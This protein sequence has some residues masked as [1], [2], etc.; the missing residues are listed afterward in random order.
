MA[1]P[2]AQRIS[3]QQSRRQTSPWRS[4]RRREPR[5]GAPSRGSPRDGRSR[6]GLRDAPHPLRERVS[7]R[8]GAA[9]YLARRVAGRWLSTAALAEPGPA[10]G[11]AVPLAPVAPAA[12]S[13][14]VAALT[15]GLE[16]A[17]ARMLDAR[18]RR[19]VALERG[20]L[21]RMGPLLLELA[22]R[23]AYRELGFRSLDAHARERLG[24]APRKARA[25]LRLERASCASPTLAA[26][27]RAGSLSGSHAQALVAL[28]LAEGSCRWVP[29]WI[30][31]AARV[32][33]R[34]LEDDVDHALATG[35]L[36]PAALPALPGPP[37]LEVPV[38]PAGVQTGARPRAGRER[39]RV[40]IHAPVEVVRL[41]HGARLLLLR[42]PAR[43]SR[44]VPLGRGRG[45]AREPDDA[46]RGPPPAQRARTPSGRAP[47]RLRF[48]TPLGSWASGDVLRT[49]RPRTSPAAGPR[50]RS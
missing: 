38:D 16:A 43:P 35:N 5:C 20:L 36:D 18:L 41:L 19:A 32:S 28:V 45:R 30:A 2:V 6:G 24:M 27:W 23:G 1:E 11:P 3:R 22:C 26:A 50:C 8:W 31:R 14:F 7:A 10:D 40:R 34:R 21:V 47:E 49:P 25:L 13:R 17:G 33:L 9:R 12:P 48:E 37:P 29:A 46:L 42:E 4:W 39:N 15:D 44:A